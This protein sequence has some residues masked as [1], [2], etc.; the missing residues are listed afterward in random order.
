MPLTHSQSHTH[1]PQFRNSSFRKRWH[2]ASSSSGGSF[3]L[4]GIDDGLGVTI[5]AA[6]GADLVHL[7]RL[8]DLA[9]G[10]GS[11]LQGGRGTIGSE[12]GVSVA[13]D[14]AVGVVAAHVGGFLVVLAGCTL[15]D[16]SRTG[17]EG[18]LNFSQIT[19]STGL[20]WMSLVGLQR[21]EGRRL[22]WG[23]M[24]RRGV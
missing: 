11:L 12:D 19:W 8:P 24:R 5:E 18:R 14:V 2:S 16:F 9:A 3:G 23:E 4:P 22:G 10:A 21:L 1:N 13:A 7:E 6:D 20:V 17:V 15:M